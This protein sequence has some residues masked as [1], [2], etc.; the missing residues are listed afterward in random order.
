MPAWCGSTNVTRARFGI[1]DARQA[2]GKEIEEII[3]TSL[4]REVVRNWPAAAARHPRCQRRILRRHAHP[5]SGDDAGETMGA[6]GFA[7]YDKLQPLQP[8][9]A[10]AVAAAAPAG[11][12]AAAPGRGTTCQRNLH[13]LH[14]QQPVAI[15]VKQQALRSTARFTVLLLAKPAIGEIARI[16]GHPRRPV[17]AGALSVGFN[18]WRGDSLTPCSKLN[19]HAAPG[20]C[21]YADRRPASV[22]STGQRRHPLRRD[23]RITPPTLQA[24]P[25]RPAGSTRSSR[26]AATRWSDRRASSPRLRA[27]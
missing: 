20:A 10:N 16:I 3:P 25:A 17:R 26:S 7:L 9:Y 14:R 2:I 8:F 24:A 18:V 1:A 13:A 12:D 15:K 5:G 21:Q 27:I 6:I 11:T 23:R 19:A 22:S 4:M